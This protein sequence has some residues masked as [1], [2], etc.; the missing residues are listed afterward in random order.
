M[1]GDREHGRG[2]S[3]EPPSQFTPERLQTWRNQPALVLRGDPRICLREDDFDQV[4]RRFEE[5][6]LPVHA[7]EERTIAAPRR[8]VQRIFD[9]EPR[10][11][12]QACLRP[13]ELPWN[14]AQTL[15]AR[16]AAA[17]RRA[18]ADAQAPQFRLRRR[19]VK[20]V[21]K[22]RMVEYDRAVRGPR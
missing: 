18:A 1:T 14:G 11:Q 7:F 2:R 10:C 20:V 9:A 4:E 15:D 22:P 13:C 17:P 21:E 16:P 6:P 3:I 8:L 19:G 5:R 12:Q